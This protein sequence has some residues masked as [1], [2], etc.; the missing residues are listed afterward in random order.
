M[1]KPLKAPAEVVNLGRGFVT[2]WQSGN[3]GK[4]TDKKVR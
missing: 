3:H 4:E 2:K 1:E